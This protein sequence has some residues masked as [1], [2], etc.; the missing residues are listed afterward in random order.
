MPQNIEDGLLRILNLRLGVIVRTE[1]DYQ[2]YYERRCARLRQQRPNTEM[3]GALFDAGIRQ[4]EKTH[5][6][7][8]DLLAARNAMIDATPT[9]THEAI[10]GINERMRKVS[11]ETLQDQ[12][13]EIVKHV[14][15]INSKAL[16][17]FKDILLTPH[18]DP[19][20]YLNDLIDDAIRDESE[21][22]RPSIKFRIA[23]LWKEYEMLG[24]ILQ[25]GIL[26]RELAAIYRGLLYS[27]I[28]NELGDDIDRGE[29][30][31]AI[32]SLESS[33]P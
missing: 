21:I 33:N 3:L 10:E 18:D 2:K 14:E 22:V 4:T 8:Q 16:S 32:I 26:L 25:T 27:G 28:M 9:D 7:V 30:Q 15:Q 19:N 5:T 12:S 17:Y 1:A 11:S 29:L 31:N 24:N 23:L 13:P 6:V 20:L